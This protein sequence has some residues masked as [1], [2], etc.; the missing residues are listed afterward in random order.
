MIE[1]LEQLEAKRKKVYQQMEAVGDFRPGM[2]SE[3]FRKCG[4]QRCVCTG[5]DHPG[6]GPQYLWN[7]TQSGKSRAQNVHLGPELRKIQQEIKNYKAFNRLYQEAIEVNE[8][9]C[10]LRPIPEIEDQ[11][12]LTALKK[13]LLRSF[14]LRRRKK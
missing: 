1:L 14:L 11:N 12:E 5:P 4:K 6:H 2:I 8:R 9:I 3:N 10:R 7:T 13:K